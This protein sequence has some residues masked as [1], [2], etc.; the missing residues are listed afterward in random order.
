MVKSK[1]PGAAA[2]KSKSRTVSKTKQTQRTKTRTPTQTVSV[3]DAAKSVDVAA[4][5]PKYTWERLHKLIGDPTEQERRIFAENIAATELVKAGASVRSERIL[6]DGLR[7]LGQ[8]WM[9]WSKL[10][11]QEKERVK[12]FSDGRLRVTLGH[13]LALRQ[14]VERNQAAPSRVAS[15]AKAVAEAEARMRY[16]KLLRRQ[17]RVALEESSRG[18]PSLVASLRAVDVKTQDAK[19]L[20]KALRDL[21]AVGRSVLASE[22]ALAEA[23]RTDGI[24]EAYLS[25]IEQHAAALEA[26][27]G[28]R[29]VLAETPVPQSEID[30]LDGLCI[31]AMRRMRRVFSL[32]KNVDPRVPTLAAIATRSVF[33]R[34]AKTRADSTSD[35]HPGDNS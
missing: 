18:R 33:V 1:R 14:A 31:A 17:L 7:W 35:G 9:Y 16:G 13:F 24:D 15:H 4:L 2:A 3:K 28:D 11:Q 8:L 34:K 19:Q 12:G 32:Q 29:G 10:T 22:R 21:V 25:S 6:T 20:S 27:A 23:L 5:P 26:D 30:R